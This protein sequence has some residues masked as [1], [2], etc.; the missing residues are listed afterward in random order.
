MWGG[1]GVSMAGR[2]FYAIGVKI[3]R[4]AITQGWL[5]TKFGA[6][7]IGAIHIT[8]VMGGLHARADV[9]LSSHL[10]NSCTDGAEI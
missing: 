8:Q 5:V 4:R 9:S 6:R 1:G 3:V 2:A 7:F 10:G